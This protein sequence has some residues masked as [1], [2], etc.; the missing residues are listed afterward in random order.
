LRTAD[1]YRMVQLREFSSVNYLS[2]L[3]QARK[4]FIHA[5]RL[6]QCSV[7]LLRIMVEVSAALT[8]QT[9]TELQWHTLHN[10][11]EAQ[12]LVFNKSLFSRDRVRFSRPLRK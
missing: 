9:A 3:S 5:I 2:I 10:S 8:V 6:V 11:S 12:K 4:R 7:R 1:F